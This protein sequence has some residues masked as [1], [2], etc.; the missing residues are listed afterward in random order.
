MSLSA[1][2]QAISSALLSLDYLLWH[3]AV[4]HALTPNYEFGIESRVVAEVPLYHQ[5][6]RY[7]LPSL[8]TAGWALLGLAMLAGVAGRER[9]E[10]TI[11]AALTSLTVSSLSFAI[12]HW[13][14]RTFLSLYSIAWGDFGRHI[15][16][17]LPVA[18][19]AGGL[20][21][22]V[23]YYSALMVSLSLLLAVALVLEALTLALQFVLP[24]VTAIA[25]LPAARREAI[26]LWSLYMQSLASPFVILLCVY[27]SSFLMG[28]AGLQIGM[29]LLAPLSVTLIVG[30][31]GIY[32][33]QGLSYMASSISI[34]IWPGLLR[35]FRRHIS[36]DDRMQ[37]MERESDDS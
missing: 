1:L 24:V 9:A 29:L 27:L 16:Y 37:D 6:L 30:I 13:T 19:H 22:L 10:R 18:A 32:L 5:L 11:A 28:Y 3:F 33:G 4:M 35:S 12:T 34:A 2:V 14:E 15:S 21:L 17:P 26:R 20:I 31:G 25:I 8:D 23:L 36:R 7:A